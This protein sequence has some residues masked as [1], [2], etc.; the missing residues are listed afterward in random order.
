[1]KRWFAALL[2]AA[3]SLAALAQAAAPA[4]APPP[5]TEKLFAVEIRTGPAWQADKPPQQQTHF[6]EH[7]AYLARLRAEGRIVF[8]ARYGEKGLI[9][10]RAPSLE[11]ARG[12]VDEDVA[13]RSGLFTYEL[14]EMRVFYGG[15]LSR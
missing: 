8:G 7:S 3:T 4:S 2:L 15:T 10:L 11:A 13:M 14:N 9:V 12:T 5:S 1:M 6:R